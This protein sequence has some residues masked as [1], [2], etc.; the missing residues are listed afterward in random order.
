MNRESILTVVIQDRNSR[1]VGWVLWHPNLGAEAGKCVFLP[2]PVEADLVERTAAQAIYD[3][4]QEGRESDWHVT[5]HEPLSVT[6]TTPGLPD[7][8]FVEFRLGSTSIWGLGEGSSRRET[9]IIR[10]ADCYKSA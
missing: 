8:M 9:G 10:P 6:I 5:S 2:L 7:V 4:Q 1:H 3:R